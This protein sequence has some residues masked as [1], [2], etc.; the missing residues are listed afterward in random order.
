MPTYTS[1]T[2]SAPIK[3][4]IRSSLVF[5]AYFY[6][7]FVVPAFR[8]RILSSVLGLTFKNRNILHNY[9]RRTTEKKLGIQWRKCKISEQNNLTIMYGI[10]LNNNLATTNPFTFP[11][12][13]LIIWYYLNFV[14][15][16]IRHFSVECQT[17]RIRQLQIL[18][19][20]R[21]FDSP[22]LTIFLSNLY[23]SLP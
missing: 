23:M 22:I 8:L 9:L 15:R 10:S 13:I 4:H 18:R 6:F 12:Y 17:L 2:D 7:N 20:L 14:M 19:H 1:F 16:V 5:S 11:R 3:R 21:P